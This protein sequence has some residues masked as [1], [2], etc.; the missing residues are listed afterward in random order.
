M[1]VL[2]GVDTHGRSSGLN[3]RP[4]T[5]VL[6]NDDQE[7]A[8]VLSALLS[9]LAEP[10]V[11]VIRMGGP[12]RSHML[13]ERIL[14]PI[15]GADGSPHS[16][17]NARL[18]ARTIAERQGQETLIVLLIMHAE[19]LQPGVLRSLQ[20]MAPY[21]EQAGHPTLRVAFI[22]R[23]AFRALLDGED[24][25]PLRA[26]LGTDAESPRQGEPARTQSA[27]PVVDAPG[28]ASN[29][30]GRPFPATLPRE[31]TAEGGG[32]MHLRQAMA[33][34]PARQ[35]GRSILRS[36]LAAVILMAGCGAAY[37]G[38][39][40]MFYREVPAR[41]AMSA[42]PP[43]VP[44]AP[45]PFPAPVEP[46]ALSEN[47]QSSAPP[48]AEAQH[49]VVPEGYMDR[50]PQ[51]ADTLAAS[52]THLDLRPDPRIV[53]HVPAG[54]APAAA[55]SAQLLRRFG[56]RPGKVEARRVADTPSRPSVRFFHPEDEPT[57]RQV[58]ASMSDVGLD[59]AIR[60]FS[61][62]QPRPS[63]GTIEVWL[64]RTP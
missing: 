23:P 11:R 5:A 47:V 43:A 8:K 57:A 24:L 54:S 48:L 50:R 36:L 42:A 14:A 49:D 39:H 40:R 35:R 33:L 2:A 28:L 4:F 34:S 32:A 44:I 6:V 56:S 62:F 59:W 58:A 55:L 29:A 64:P 41:P 27:R 45:V 17:D 21:F 20:A 51:G 53:L 15:T 60:D 26:A 13:L 7:R 18:I 63:R 38:L 31:M 3:G 30:L 25:A 12:S 16:A 9:S 19:R 52:A 46:S 10:G 61:T 22:G 37:L 1:S